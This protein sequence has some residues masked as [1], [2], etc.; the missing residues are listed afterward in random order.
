MSI[1]TFVLVEETDV[2]FTA[3]PLPVGG[4]CQFAFQLVC[5]ELLSSGKQRHYSVSRKNVYL[6]CRF[7]LFVCVEVACLILRKRKESNPI[8]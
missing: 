5:I 7:V 3:R 8:K 2:P 4:Q 6:C 1:Q